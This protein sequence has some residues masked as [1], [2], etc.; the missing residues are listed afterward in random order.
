MYDFQSLFSTTSES[1]YRMCDL[2]ARVECP[3]GAP[4]A[5]T[6]FEVGL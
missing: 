1:W 6:I 4:S 3:D 2:W 5:Y